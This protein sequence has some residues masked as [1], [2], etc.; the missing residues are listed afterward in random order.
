MYKWPQGRVIRTICL[1]LTLV[2]VAD[3]AYNGAYGRFSAY[4]QTP[5]VSQLGLGIAFAT[6]SLAGLVAGLVMVGFHHRCVDFLIEV[7]GE[8]LRVEWP[9]AG[10]VWRST[11]TI[12]VVVVLLA[13]VLAVFDYLFVFA[14]K[15]GLQVV[16]GWL[17]GDQFAPK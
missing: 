2:I 13:I 7:E 9:K 10:V 1:L 11:A 17:A 5:V 15:D 12:A 14:I 8:M 6:L 3:L 4:S 16:A